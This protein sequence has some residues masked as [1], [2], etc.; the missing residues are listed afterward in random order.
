MKEILGFIVLTG[1]LF[2][3][4][5]FV[6]ASVVIVI[7]ASR[8]GRKRGKRWGRWA[9]LILLL[10]AFWDLPPTLGMFWYQCRYNA[11]FSQY[12]TLEEWKAENPG[13][14]ETLTPVEKVR[15]TRIGNVDR[16]PLNQRFAW[17]VERTRMPLRFE[18]RE[19]QVVDIETGEVLADYRDFSTGRR[20]ME[21]SPGWNPRDYKF[22]L[23]YRSCEVGRT[24]PEQVKFNGYKQMVKSLGRAN[25]GD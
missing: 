2:Y 6:V 20:G 14:A 22:W 11:G 23:N 19:L 24:M 1:P 25:N 13:I 9:A 15:S 5:V 17:E 21:W 10:I 7:I 12:K 18:R 4:L 8:E 3:L 16:Y